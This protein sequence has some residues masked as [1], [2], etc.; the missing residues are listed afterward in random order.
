[1]TEESES[2]KLQTG[3]VKN[4]FFCEAIYRTVSHS[5]NQLECELAKL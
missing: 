2:W 1:M 3:E 5:Q 4:F